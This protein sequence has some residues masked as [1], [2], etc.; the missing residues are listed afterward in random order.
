MTTIVET[1]FSVM[2][3]LMKKLVIK[4][5]VIMTYTTTAISV[6]PPKDNIHVL[7]C[8]HNLSA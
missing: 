7:S 8:I 4:T 6:V 3:L 5:Q 1:I 2:P